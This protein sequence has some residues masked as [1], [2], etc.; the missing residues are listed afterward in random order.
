MDR[1][2]E[3]RSVVRRRLTSSTVPL[4]PAMVTMSPFEYWFS[5][6]MNAP[7]T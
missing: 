5:I 2:V 7:A 6:R 3:S 1:S 4:T